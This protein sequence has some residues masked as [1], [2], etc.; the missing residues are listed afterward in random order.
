MCVQ[1]QIINKQ[2]PPSSTV[3]PLFHLIPIII[4]ICTSALHTIYVIRSV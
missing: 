3:Q 1:L 2:Q 4:V